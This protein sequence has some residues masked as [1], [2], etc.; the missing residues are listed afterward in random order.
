[1]EPESK[2]VT[3]NESGRSQHGLKSN[4]LTFFDTIVMALAGTAPAF[5]IA[6]TTG[7]LIVAVGFASPAALLYCAVPMLGIAWAFAHLNRL[8]PNCSGTYAWVGRTLHPI[9]GFA[10]GWCVVVSVT[11]F[12]VAGSVPVASLTLG[13]FSNSLANNLGAVT[14]LGCAFLLVI[15]GIVMFGVTISARAQW[16]MTGI[17]IVLLLV[18]AVLALVHLPGHTQARFSWSWFGGSHFQSLSGFAVGALI[19]AYYYWGWDVTANLSEETRN[20]RRA[21]GLGGI[22]GV[23]IV[24][25]LFELFTIVI[26]M[27][28]PAKTIAANTA[29]LLSVLGREVWPTAGGKV[30]VVAVLLSSLATLETALIQSTRTLLAMSA[31]RVMPQ[32]LGKIHPRWRTPWFSA[33]LLTVIAVGLFVA[34]NYVGSVSTLLSDAVAAIGLE[35][36]VYYGLAGIAVAVAYRKVLLRSWSNFILIGAW[37]LLGGIF[38]LWVFGE[39]ISSLGG[40]IDAVGLGAIGLGLIPLGYYMWKRSPALRRSEGRTLVA[41]VA[42][43]T[44]ASP[45]AVAE[46]NLASGASATAAVG[47]AKPGR[48]LG[49]ADPLV[50]AGLRRR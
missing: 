42:G 39:S 49:G 17:E 11:L 26:Q 22:V 20:S 28:L 12:M 10:A 14:I 24:L 38:M 21:S 32:V 6:A 35:I 40:T 3:E 29:N 37:P 16:I 7:V 33:V 41:T 46:T 2:H 43:G 45:R 36:A 31:D 23:V 13:L 44:A 9:L 34:A 48:P 25:V 18:F 15:L 4:A 50:E 8:E 30:I 27:L 1:V 47:G 19:A 5:S